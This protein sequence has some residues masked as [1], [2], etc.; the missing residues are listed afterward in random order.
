MIK[1]LAKRAPREQI[2][3]ARI[4]LAKHSPA[5]AAQMFQYVDQ[6]RVRLAE[7]LPW[8]DLTQTVADE[9]KFI[10][11]A[12]EQWDQLQLFDFG[13]FRKEDGMYLGNIGV[14]TISWQHQRAELG[15]WILGNFEGKGYMSEAVGLIE[16]ELFSMGFNR[17]E[18]HCS[19]L[20]EKSAAVPK[21]CGYR[22]EGHLRQ[23]GIE[24]DR[25][26][27]TLVF[28]K[29]RSDWEASASSR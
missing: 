4:Y 20:N 5:L 29:I 8:V 14:H 2:E 11:S 19:S 22:L 21:R 25:Y 28:G 7:F 6:D 27:D 12:R 26:R 16:S 24:R 15:Y 18:I 17:V 9:E 23:D 10:R 1:P 3:G 13:I